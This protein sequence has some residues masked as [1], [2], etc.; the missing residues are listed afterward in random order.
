MND[1]PQTQVPITAADESFTH[2]LVAPH[3]DVLY[4]D[5]RWADRCYHQ[6]TVEDLTV[7]LGRQL[8]PYDGRRFAFAGVADTRTQYAVRAAE[9]FEIGDDPNQARIGSVTIEV[10]DP[11]RRIRLQTHKPDAPIAVDLTFTG[12]FPA[13]AS[14]PHLIEQDGEAVTH[15]MNF[16]QS[17]VYDGTIRVAD[18]TYEVT[19]R[20]G[21]RDRGW[22]LR[23]HEAS[24]RR[25][26][27]IAA[28]CELPDAA[29]YL[30]LFETASG[31]RAFTNGWLLDDGGV[32][33]DV[34]SVHHDVD[35]DG[36]LVTG[37][38]LEV[39]FASGA[40][41]TVTFDVLGRSYLS[42]IG[43]ALEEELRQPGTDSFDLTD[44]ATVARLDGQNDQ[45]CRFDVDGSEGYGYVETGVGTHVRY[46]PEA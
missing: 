25:G 3:A 10:E 32:A 45:S 4:R 19:E 16:F 11:L 44:P 40:Q 15:Y 5:P 24:G 23:K 42:A 27:M 35:L 29:L 22:G 28:Y 20:F 36:T 26:F 7:N 9:S 41:R 18:R 12:R 21:F 13:V 38:R 8:Y 43:Y 30:L 33:D 46:R 1:H 37:G 14:Q 6:L 2:Q 39:G 31:Q 17:G 34:T